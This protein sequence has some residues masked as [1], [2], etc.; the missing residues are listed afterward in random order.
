[1]VLADPEGSSLF[2]RVQSG[3]CYTPQQSERSVRRH[4]YDSIVE[5]VGI[6]R[7]TAN[8]EQAC[9]HSAVRVSDQDLL[10][11]AHWLLREEG[12]FAGSSSAL[13]V[14]AAC[15]VALQ[16]GPGHTVVTVVCDNGGRHLS[17]FWNPQYVSKYKLIW[18]DENREDF[19]PSFLR[20]RPHSSSHRKGSETSAVCR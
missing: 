8:F 7:I 4:R 2:H 14:A 10:D 5:G 18:P 17:R 19:L 12:I 15:Q 3:V 20:D 9:V 6:D 11:T 16:L 1:M 13:N